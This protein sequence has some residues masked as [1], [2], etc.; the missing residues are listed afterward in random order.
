MEY[1]IDSPLFVIL[2][3]AR[4]PNRKC[5]LNLNNYPN[6]H[7]QTYNKIKIIYNKVMLSK[8]YRLKL[9]PP[10]S[11]HFKLFKRDKRK[12]DRANALSVVEKFFCDALVN[13]GCIP[14]DNDSIIESTHYSTGGI[15]RKNPR[16]EIIIKEV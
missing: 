16:C 14:D 13:H 6:W 7:Y 3:M 4:K 9:K 5:Y 15:D 10:I 1:K 2:K 12:T 8:L 11:L